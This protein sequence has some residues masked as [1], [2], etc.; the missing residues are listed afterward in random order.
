MMVISYQSIKEAKPIMKLP[1][2]HKIRP[3]TTCAL[4]LLVPVSIFA[5][6]PTNADRDAAI[7]SGDFAAYSTKLSAWLNMKIPAGGGISANTLG[8]LLKDPVFANTLAQRQF[9][10]K[11]GADALTALTKDESGKKFLTWILQSTEA[12]EHCLEGVTPVASNERAS[13]SYRIPL[14]SLNIWKRIYEADPESR[15]GLYLKLAIATGQNPPGTG[16]RGAGQAE[17]AADPLSRYQHFKSAHKNGELFPSFD[18]LSV[19]E[20][21]QIVSSNASN[22]DLAWAR[23]AINT[24]RPDLRVNQLVV[25]TTSE[26]WRR[27]SPVPFGH[28][29]KNVLA[30]GGKCGPRSSWSVF[31]CQAFGI[32]AVGVRQPGHVCAT[33]KSSDP[34]V[35]P[36]PGNVWKVVYGRGWHVSKTCGLAGPAFM[37]EM[38]IRL[39]AARFMQT[40]RLR[41]L[42]SALDSKERSNAVT[43]VAA[44]MKVP[45]KIARTKPTTGST[46]QAARGAAVASLGAKT[47]PPLKLMPGVIHVEAESFRTSKGVAVHDCFLGGKQVYSPKYGQNWGTRPQIEYVIDVSR[48]GTYGLTMRAAVVNFHQAINVAVGADQT[49][50]VKLANSNGL[51]QTTPEVEVRLQK[52]KQTLTLTRPNSQRGLALRYLELKAKK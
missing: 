7:N 38:K 18:H 22:A 45:E 12:M 28:S 32:P 34:R 44:V 37:E 4:L 35:Q 33:Y 50:S 10:A 43:K 48:T 6:Q 23:E 24:W 49:V 25:N 52:G 16:N 41:W 26:V 30:G 36:Q 2:N 13:Q 40:E 17:K 14:G 1:T 3:L 46:G 31:V 9:I 20:Y 42:A 15:S 51:W 21:R 39:N 47:E 19:W 5:G 27:N 11:T 29:F 8:T